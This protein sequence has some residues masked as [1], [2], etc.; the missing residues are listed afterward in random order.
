MHTS[1]QL[2]DWQG[3]SNTAIKKMEAEIDKLNVII[4]QAESDKGRSRDWVLAT[5]AAAREKTV[6]A[7]GAALKT[8]QTLAETTGTQSKFWESKPFLL[9]LQTFDEDPA[10]DA[11]IRLAHAAELTNAPLPLL[12]LALEN[13]RFDKNL[14]QIFQCWRAGFARTGEAG[15]SDVV[16]LA[17][18]DLAIPGQAI[19]L[20]AISTCSSNLSYAQ[21]MGSVAI[22]NRS[23]PTRRMQVAREQQVS[24]RFVSAA[25]AIGA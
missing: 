6:A 13:A 1:T 4:E 25:A 22:G 2:Q 17:L 20:A 11:Q 7:C 18:G 24:S 8:V 16:N 10:K 9:S 23:D 21:S 14:A 19:A 3:Q 15:F 5:V 12:G